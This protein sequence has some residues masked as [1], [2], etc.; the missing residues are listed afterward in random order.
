MIEYHPLFNHH[1]NHPYL[2]MLTLQTPQ[3]TVHSSEVADAWL[4]WHSIP[5]MFQSM[6]SCCDQCCCYAAEFHSQRS[7]IWFRQMAQLSTTISIISLLSTL[8]IRDGLI[9]TPSPQSNSIPLYTRKKRVSNL[10]DLAIQANYLLDF[11]SLLFSYVFCFALDFRLFLLCRWYFIYIHG[12][13][14]VGIAEWVCSGEKSCKWDGS[15]PR[16]VVVVQH[17]SFHQSKPIMLQWNHYY[18]W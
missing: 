13:W 18:H 17:R 1:V 16:V 6:R 3:A 8:H 12:S 4:A 5:K 7:M 10:H 9:F 14:H 15:R 2:C 11:K